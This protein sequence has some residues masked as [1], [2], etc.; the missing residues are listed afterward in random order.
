[1]PKPLDDRDCRLLD[2]L[3]RDAWQSYVDLGRRVNLSASAVQRRVE[4]LRRDGVLLGARATVAKSANS[5]GL[6]IYALVELADDRSTTVNRFRRQIGAD[7][8]LLEAAEA[9]VR[10]LGVPKDRYEFQMLLGVREKLR[11]GLLAKGHPVR[12]YVPF[13][14]AWYGYSVRRLRENPAIAGHVFRALI[15]LG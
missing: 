14:R 7:E 9:T 15:G 1:M 2:L 4:R 13:G 12:I 11:D 10:E 3:G 8:A 6:R 5:Q